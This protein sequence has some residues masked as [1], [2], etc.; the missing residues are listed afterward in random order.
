[1]QNLTETRKYFGTDGIRGVY[2]EDLT[3]GLAMLVGNSLG[4]AAAGGTV[5]IGRD[6]RNG[7]ENLARALAEGVLAAAGNVVDLGVVTTPCVSFVTKETGASAGVMVSASHNPPRYN[8]IKVFGPDGRKLAR[9]REALVEKHIA[10]AKLCYAEYR[11]EVRSAAGLTESYKSA[12]CAAA[13]SLDGLRVVLDCANGA[14]AYTAPEIFSRLGAEVFPVFTS[15]DGAL[16]NEGCGALHPDAVAEEVVRRGADIGLCFDGDADR[17]IAADENGKTV[18][19]DMTIYILARKMKA[20]G[21][22]P[23]SA[24]VG[25]LHTNMGVEAGLAKLGIDLVRTDIGDHNVIRCMCEAGLA[26]GGEQS[27]HIILS[28]FLPTGDG[29]FAGAKLARVLKESGK[30]LSELADCQVF[31]QR[32]AEVATRHKEKIARDKTLLRYVAAIED[33]LG[34]SGRIMLR[35]SGTE[36][37]LRI[38]AESRDAFLADFAA[39]SI[40]LFIRTQIE[41]L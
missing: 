33:M 5:V 11:G 22:L 15:H 19:G 4:L 40:E 38:M 8:G 6:N 18:D 16:I 34:D 12:V 32:N 1:M 37:K 30:K 39:R 28:E 27:G 36:K 24:A 20:E 29:V 26:L 13:G 41:L 21:R 31:P 9:E 17:V 14:A 25:T 2:G 35:P 10:D 7:G 23:C 3:D